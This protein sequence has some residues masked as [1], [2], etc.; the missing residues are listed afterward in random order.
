MTTVL[1]RLSTQSRAIAPKLDVA[2]VVVHYRTPAAVQRCVD[3]LAVEDL[4]EVIVVDNSAPEQAIGLV[5]PTPG[6]RLCVIAS[7]SNLGF[8]RGC[9]VGAHASQSPLLL[10]MNADVELRRGAVSALRDAITADERRAVVGPRIWDAGGNIE[11]SARDFPRWHTGVLGRRSRVTQALAKR[12]R[13]PAG[14]SAAHGC[15]QSV[16][17]VSG[18]CQLVRRDAFIEVGGFDEGYW[19]YWEDADFCRRL[20][21]RGLLTWFAP[22]AE[23]DHY[24][25]ASGRNRRT[26]SEFHNSAARFYELHLARGSL[27]AKLVRMGLRCRSGLESR[28]LDWPTL[29]TYAAPARAVAP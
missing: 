3:A 28:R 12:G 9:N 14:L 8:A 5:E 20:A 21:H 16:D 18:A 13:P 6:P 1:P 19:M 7:T 4:A 15:A 27:D 29:A 2:A 26:V 22:D 25:G 10:F 24:T 23:V 17:W 11:L